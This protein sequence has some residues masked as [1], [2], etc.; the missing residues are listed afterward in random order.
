[1]IR[2]ENSYDVLECSFLLWPVFLHPSVFLR[3]QQLTDCSDDV[4]NSDA[5]PSL[6]FIHLID[7]SPDGN[8]TFAAMLSTN[9]PSSNTTGHSVREWWVPS[10]CL[11]LLRTRRNGESPFVPISL[12]ANIVLNPP[13]PQTVYVLQS[14]VALD[15]DVCLKVFVVSSDMVGNRSWY[16]CDHHGTVR[17]IQHLP[18]TNA[19]LA[20]YER[21]EADGDA[22]SDW[23]FEVEKMSSPT[24]ES[25][26]SECDSD[27]DKVS[28][29]SFS[30]ND[31]EDVE[32]PT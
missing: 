12:D 28:V 26:N 19:I 23:P 14:V 22:I 17:E 10:S 21:S 15:S 20:I 13:S 2:R 5:N 32:A 7:G 16:E 24:A 11:L 1:M 8:Q 18:P 27:E 25:S 4:G 30:E 29:Q 3:R 9:V 31:S 6:P